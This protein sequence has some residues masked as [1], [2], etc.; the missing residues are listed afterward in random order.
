MTTQ[1]R[2]LTLTESTNPFLRTRR[3]HAAETTEDYVEAIRDRI[4]GGATCRCCDLA[5]FFGVTHVTVHRIVARMSRDG[6]VTM[7]PYRPIQLTAK[8][9]RLA[10]K[11]RHRHE[12]VFQFLRSIGVS[13]DVAR[14]DAE[15][16]EHH[17]SEQTMKAFQRHIDRDPQ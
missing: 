6:F 9:S 17:V 16:M 10:K 14:I 13:E 7:E 4:E 3:D 8:G 2:S 15:G 12:V 5:R 11:V 1:D